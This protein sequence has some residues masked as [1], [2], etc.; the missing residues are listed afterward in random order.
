MADSA[1]SNDPLERYG[2]IERAYCEERWTAVIHDGQALVADLSR[3]EEAPPEGLTERLQLLIAHAF[4]YGLGDRDSAED[5]YQAVLRSGAEASLRQIAEQGL[6]QC[7]LP[8]AAADSQGEEQEQHDPLSDLVPAPSASTSVWADVATAEPPADF[9]D[10]IGSGP[11]S[12]LQEESIALQGL[13]DSWGAPAPQAP[14]GEA[15][16]LSWLTAEA[17][18]APQTSAAPPVMPW[19]EADPTAAAAS[20]ALIQSPASD[21]ADLTLHQDPQER[22]PQESVSA[23]LPSQEDPAAMP[24]AAIPAQVVAWAELPMADAESGSEPVPADGENA[25]LFHADATASLQVTTA[26]FESQPDTVAAAVTGEGLAGSLAAPESTAVIPHGPEGSEV[27]PARSP[28]RQDEER[29]VAEIVDEPELI[30]LYQADR[31]RRQELLIQPDADRF[32]LPSAAED[33]PQI[34]GEPGLLPA[35]ERRGSE[36]IAGV[37]QDRR[38]EPELDPLPA[39]A[40]EPAPVPT[41]DLSPVPIGLGMKPF[42]DPPEPVAEEDPEMLMGLL[43]VEMG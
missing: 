3:L 38:A 35:G 32:Q 18:S 27:L 41:P 5:F 25:S 34:P 23:S 13:Q 40:E 29:L 19:L 4:L 8:I 11:A 33:D 20:G 26:A 37:F 28:S 17:T 6:Q 14:S 2:A 21:A 39:E 9:A 43:K 36:D 12:T 15:A 24:P 31:L 16:A 10:S 1:L 22:H 7:A 42:S 30:E